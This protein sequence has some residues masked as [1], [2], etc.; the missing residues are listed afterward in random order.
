MGERGGWACWLSG[1]LNAV[2]DVLGQAMDGGG[3]VAEGI[4]FRSAPIHE[5]FGAGDGLG[6][7]VSYGVKV[8]ESLALPCVGVAEL[9]KSSLAVVSM[10]RS[11]PVLVMQNRP[12]LKAWNRNG[13]ANVIC[14]GHVNRFVK[15]RVV[16]TVEHHP[17]G[18]PIRQP[19]LC[20]A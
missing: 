9:G 10:G 2:A 15:V 20:G 12:K 3:G 16:V 5:H 7:V 8:A 6:V 17:I 14:L 13:E 18:V 11:V 4:A 19:V 1:T